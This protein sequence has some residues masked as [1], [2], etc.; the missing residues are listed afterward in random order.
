MINKIF[1]YLYHFPAE[2]LLKNP[3]FYLSSESPPSSRTFPFSRTNILMHF[4]IVLILW[5]IMMVVLP[6]IAFSRASWT[7]LYES[8]SNA[9]VA[10][11][12]NKTFGF[13]IIVLAIATR[14]FWPPESFPP[15]I[16]HWV[17]KPELS[18]SSKSSSPLS[19]TSPSIA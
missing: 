15:L 1:I 2:S 5:A 12:S 17:W 4:S 16:P 11:S 10:S 7:F 13:L 14:C 6:F 9:D 19:S 8:S 3:P 18:S